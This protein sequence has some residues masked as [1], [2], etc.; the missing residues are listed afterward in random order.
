L[1]VAVRISDMDADRIR[2][3]AEGL[4]DITY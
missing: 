2:K 1:R 4:L 3:I